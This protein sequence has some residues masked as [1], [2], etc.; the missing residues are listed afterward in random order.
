M[1]QS[2]IV[3]TVSHCHGDHKRQRIRSV[4]KPYLCP[5]CHR[6][7]KLRGVGHSYDCEKASIE[8]VRK[9]CERSLLHEK[10]ARDKAE[11]WLLECRRLHA[12][13]MAV[14]NELRKLRNS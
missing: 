5:I 6:G 8:D 12:S 9:E 4:P 1:K 13:L 14:K 7:I 11:T 3:E 2:S 10:W